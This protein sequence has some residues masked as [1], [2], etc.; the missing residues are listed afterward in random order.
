VVNNV[1][2]KRKR[3]PGPVT[4][5]FSAMFILLNGVQS[6]TLQ[7]GKEIIIANSPTD[8]NVS[9]QLE[10]FFAIMIITFVCQLLAYS[11]SIYIRIG[12]ILALLKVISLVFISLCGVAALAKARVKAVDEIQTPYG[13][14]DF[15]NAFASA[16]NSPYQYGLALLSV[17][18]AF[19]GY[20]NANFVSF[21][22]SLF[23][24]ICLMT[25][26]GINGNSRWSQR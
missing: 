7:M 6:N 25:Y 8:T 24:A 9:D 21:S 13:T 14:S 23:T 26:I 15:S 5:I 2:Q 17:I 16:S 19:Q 11:R 22:S 18:R 4:Y 12:N 3:L 1:I 20:E 10:K